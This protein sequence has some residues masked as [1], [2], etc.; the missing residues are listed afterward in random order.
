MNILAY[1][2]PLWL[3]EYSVCRFYH[4]SRSDT[5]QVLTEKNP[6]PL[7]GDVLQ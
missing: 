4:D 1:S 6:L 7:L 2:A 3:D 5:T